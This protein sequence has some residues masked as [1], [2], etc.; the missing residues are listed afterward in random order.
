MYFYFHTPFF[1]ARS[2]WSRAADPLEVGDISD[3]SAKNF[4]KTELSTSKEDVKDNKNEKVIIIGTT[5]EDTVQYLTGGCFVLLRR[6]VA[7][8]KNHSLSNNVFDGMLLP[9]IHVPVPQCKYL[10]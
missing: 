10:F 1:T 6:F 8:A 3:E 4:L 9:I 7:F 5:I 2:A